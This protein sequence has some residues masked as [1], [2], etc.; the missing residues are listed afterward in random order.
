MCVWGGAQAQRMTMTP[1]A[2]AERRESKYSVVDTQRNRHT[3]TYTQTH[4]K[5]FGARKEHKATYCSREEGGRESEAGEGKAALSIPTWGSGDVTVLSTGDP[6]PELTKGCMPLARSG[7]GAVL[8]ASSFP[9][10]QG[11]DTLLR[12]KGGA[13]EGDS[14]LDAEL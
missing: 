6:E 9:K 4:D 13:W 7:A 11:E 8:E 12:V 2:G 1:K 14:D 10:P 3:H 5:A